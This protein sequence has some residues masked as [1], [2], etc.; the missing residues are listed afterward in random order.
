MNSDIGKNINKIIY[1]M[2]YTLLPLLFFSLLFN[3][4]VA[5]DKAEKEEKPAAKAKAKAAKPETTDLS[6]AGKISKK[7]T[8]GKNERLYTYYYLE[9][10]GGEKVR[11]TKK[12]LGKTGIKLDDFVDASVTLTAKGYQKELK[13]KKK[14][15]YVTE[16]VKIEKE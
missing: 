3:V 12:A 6:L 5:Q 1:I 13:S 2:K 16:I 11:L 8:K 10:E 4:S 15:T 7:E 14:R 9:V